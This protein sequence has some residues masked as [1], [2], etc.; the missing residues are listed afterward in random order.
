MRRKH[1]S[2][3]IIRHAMTHLPTAQLTTKCAYSSLACGLPVTTQIKW[4]M[5]DTKSHESKRWN[6]WPLIWNDLIVRWIQM[7]RNVVR[8]RQKIS[9]NMKC[10]TVHFWKRNI[11]TIQTT[12]QQQTITNNIVSPL[13]SNYCFVYDTKWWEILMFDINN[14][15]AGTFAFRFFFFFWTCAVQC[16]HIVKL[17]VTWICLC[18]DKQL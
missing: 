5:N 14:W 11:R 3:T 16:L 10:H 2:M 12:K 4:I 8:L 6:E 17:T 18:G 9:W 13:F 7:C 15:F 1:L